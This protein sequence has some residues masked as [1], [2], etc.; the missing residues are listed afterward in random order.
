MAGNS[1][2]WP[3]KSTGITTFGA[4]S[5]QVSSSDCRSRQAVRGSMSAKAGMPP[6]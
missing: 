6:Q 4:R 5:A 2:G 1:A 3:E